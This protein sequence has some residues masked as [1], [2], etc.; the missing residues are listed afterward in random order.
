MNCVAPSGLKMASPVLE[1]LISQS[2]TGCSDDSGDLSSHTH[3][4][5][6]YKCLPLLQDMKDQ[7][8]GNTNRTDNVRLDVWGF[9][10]PGDI[11]IMQLLG[12]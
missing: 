11:L 10:E 1:F 6:S 12:C 4:L 2:L 3:V 7:R 9:R 5:W 8:L